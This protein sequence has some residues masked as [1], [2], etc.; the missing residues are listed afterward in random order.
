MSQNRR[1]LQLRARPHRRA[2][3]ATSDPVAGFKG[4][5]PG[6]EC[7]AERWKQDE[8]RGSNALGVS[9]PKL[10]IQ[11]TSLSSLFTYFSSFFFHFLAP[12]RYCCFDLHHIY[13]VT[14]VLDSL[15]LFSA[16]FQGTIFRSRGYYLRRRLASEGIVPLG[17]TLSRCVC[18]RRVAAKVLHQLSL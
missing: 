5:S 6:K 14:D 10:K 17:V 9:L 13:H 11:F 3:S 15:N 8:K 2:Y 1:R 4:G 7:W 12:S 18:V 16:H